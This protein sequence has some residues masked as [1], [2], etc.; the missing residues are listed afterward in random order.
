MCVLGP[1][2]LTAGTQDVS[3]WVGPGMCSWHSGRWG[4]VPFP[5]GG[6]SLDLS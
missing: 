3:T 6:G 5:A 2:G 1:S 4:F